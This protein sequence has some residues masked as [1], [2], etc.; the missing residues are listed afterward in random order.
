M[1]RVDAA[2]QTSNKF[3]CQTGVFADNFDPLESMRVDAHLLDF[4]S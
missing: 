3:A 1:A 2:P 4:G